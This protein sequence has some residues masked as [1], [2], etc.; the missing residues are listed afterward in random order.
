[1][2]MMTVFRLILYLL[3]CGIGICMSII[4]CFNFHGLAQIHEFICIKLQN[5][6]LLGLIASRLSIRP[7]SGQHSEADWLTRANISTGT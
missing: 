1:M 4:F 2:L 6:P 3:G 5:R 7:R